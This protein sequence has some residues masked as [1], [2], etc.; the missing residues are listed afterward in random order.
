MDKSL[1]VCLCEF[2]GNDRCLSVCVTASA[3]DLREDELCIFIAK[4]LNTVSVVYNKQS[5]NTHNIDSCIKG[6][7]RNCNNKLLFRA[8]FRKP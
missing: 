5:H 6:S 4:I 8:C 1:S 2:D 7:M 3:F